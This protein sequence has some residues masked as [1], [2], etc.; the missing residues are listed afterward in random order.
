MLLPC[1]HCSRV[2]QVI[3]KLNVDEFI[4]LVQGIF[5]LEG[6]V[7]LANQRKAMY[8]LILPLLWLGD[9]QG[10]NKLACLLAWACRRCMVRYHELGE[11]IS[12]PDGSPAPHAP[13]PRFSHYHRIAY[14]HQRLSGSDEVLHAIAAKPHV[15]PALLNLGSGATSGIG[16]AGLPRG[17]LT[18]VTDDWV[19][20]GPLGIISLCQQLTNMLIIDSWPTRAQGSL[21]VRLFE[22]RIAGADP[23]S[24]GIISRCG[25]PEGWLR[26]STSM[27]AAW[28]R[29][30]LLHLFVHGV[31]TD[32]L[33]IPIPE[34][35]VAHQKMIADL[36][37][38]SSVATKLK[39]KE[40]TRTQARAVMHRYVEGYS[41]VCSLH[42]I[43][44]F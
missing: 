32:R 39:M 11:I 9:L 35:R 43:T 26:D 10:Q 42:L 5:H 18:G 30:D 7:G 29:M 8:C 4:A 20:M 16:V 17:F 22:L 36:V 3:E 25:F 33:V 41:V 34:L 19:H 13:A 14:D 2:N 24:D 6:I 15:R 23:F 28:E 27:L 21:A 44:C 40:M 31:G 1:S 38:I 12:N 37:Y